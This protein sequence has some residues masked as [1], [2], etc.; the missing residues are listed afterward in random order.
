MG[1]GYIVKRVNQVIPNASQVNAAIAADATAGTVIDGLAYAYSKAS[2]Q[3]VRTAGAANYT[4]EVQGSYD[5]T[6][7]LDL[8][9]VTGGG[10]TDGVSYNGTSWAYFRAY[11]TTV[12]AGNTITVNLKVSE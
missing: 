1:G 4:V 3:I 7:W 12:G 10:A 6:N 2:L 8:A 11:V 5:N 9:T